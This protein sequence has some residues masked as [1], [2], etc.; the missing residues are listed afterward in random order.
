M[1]ERIVIELGK[2]ASRKMLRQMRRVKDGAMKS[3]YQIVWLYAQGHGCDAVAEALGE[4]LRLD[5]VSPPLARFS[6]AI[7]AA[8]CAR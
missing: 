8:L 1:A 6:G 4:I 3:R 2:K 5:V 7:G